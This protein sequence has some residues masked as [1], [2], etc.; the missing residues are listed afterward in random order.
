MKAEGKVIRIQAG[1]NGSIQ[2]PCETKWGY[3]T[4]NVADWDGD[5]LPDIVVNSIWGKILWYRNIGTLEE[6]ML[7]GAQ[8]IEVDWQRR[9]LKPEWNWW[10][11]KENNLVTQWRT[12]PVVID[13]NEE[14]LNDLVMLD[15][16]G[17][18][19]FFERMEKDGKL[20]L[21]PGKRIFKT[22]GPSVFDNKHRQKNTESGV[23]R[24]NNGTAGSSGRRK[25]C[26]VD[27]DLDGKLDLL[28]NSENV[29]FMHNVSNKKGEFV[30]KEMGMVDVRILAGHTT[31]PTIVN[32]DKNEVTDLLVGA[33]DEFLYY[34]RNPNKQ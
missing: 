27:W 19:A 3:T 4:L 23:L 6:P 2:G 30:F 17:Y 34:M 25:L 22:D 10:H 14:W 8:A 31:S 12:T 13:L 15:H 33:E 24:L 7:I 21:L 20:V 29:N 11:P 32:W 26:F 28:V 5:G 18:L 16:E 1:Y 9:P